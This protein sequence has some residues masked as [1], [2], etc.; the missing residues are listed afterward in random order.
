[1]KMSF[2]IL[3]DMNG[4]L[5]SLIHR[6]TDRSFGFLFPVNFVLIKSGIEIKFILFFQV[7]C[8]SEKLISH[9]SVIMTA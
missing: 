5:P 2:P 6:L 4:K 3:S 8:I 7:V 1:M 9:I